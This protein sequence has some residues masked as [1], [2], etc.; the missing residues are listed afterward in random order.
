MLS[1]FKA[2]LLKENILALAI[3][4]VIGN[5]TTALV[6]ALVADFIMPVVTAATP[7]DQ[8]ERLVANAGPVEFRVGHFAYA[9]LQFVIIAFVV[10][11][12]SR[13]FIRPK[14]AAPTKQCPYCRQNIDAAASRCAHCT[15]QLAAA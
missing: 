4:V 11:R 6:N 13:A 5:A 8:W 7:Q 15:S 2:F 12:V 14:P 10:W 1:D 9:L 3:A